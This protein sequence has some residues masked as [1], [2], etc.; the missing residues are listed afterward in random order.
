MPDKRMQPIVEQEPG[1]GGAHEAAAAVERDGQHL[2]VD[3]EEKG[4]EE[5]VLLLMKANA[6]AQALTLQ[7]WSGRW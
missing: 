7:G 5:F 1:A 6:D 2:G 3:N 4:G